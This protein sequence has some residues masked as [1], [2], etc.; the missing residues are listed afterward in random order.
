MNKEV[1]IDLEALDERDRSIL[2]EDDE[3]IMINDVYG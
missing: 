1:F 2:V 3:E